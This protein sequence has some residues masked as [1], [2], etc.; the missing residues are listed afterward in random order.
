MPKDAVDLGEPMPG[1]FLAELDSAAY[2]SV[3]AAGADR[4]FRTGAALFHQ[5][6]PSRHVV[7]IEFGWVKVTAVSRRGWEALLAIRGPG[8]V[9]GELAVL[10]A[11]P[12]LATVTA[13]TSLRGTVVSADRLTDCMRA[14]WAVAVALLRHLAKT[15]READERRMQFGASNGD[16]RLVVLLHELAGKH[17]RVI[18]DGVLIDLPLSQQDLA[19]SVGTSREVVARML[20][21][22]RSRQIVLTQR[23]QIIVVRPDLLESL[24]R[25]VSMST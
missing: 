20:R 14:N 8:D 3:R 10:D 17:G 1:S 24:A 16:S 18:D 4:V 13:L 7:I 9:V 12:R 25:S 21:V 11:R 22:L 5:G 19:A 2:A 23:R 15:V 6:D